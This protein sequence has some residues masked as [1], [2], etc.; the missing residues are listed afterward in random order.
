MHD[1]TRP[2]PRSRLGIVS[3][4]ALTA[5]ALLSARAPAQQPGT[6]GRARDACNAAAT[7]AGYVIL[8]R[9]RES[10]AG[11]V[12]SFPWHVRRGSDQVDVTCHFDGARGLV[13]LPGFERSGSAAGRVES[14]D[15]RAQRRCEDFV[16]SA[17]GY[18]VLTIGPATRRG[19]LWDVT[20][21]V[22]HRGRDGVP[23]TCRFNPSSN[24]LSI[25]R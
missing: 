1:Q 15:Q 9:D 24:R 2:M 7:R 19:T 16:N 6:W 22:R 3:F 21:T 20:M 25:K 4:A 11:G 14:Q 12:Y 18:H 23:I 5:V 10:L 8:R 17:P 13:D